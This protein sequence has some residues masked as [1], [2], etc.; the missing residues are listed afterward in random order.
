MAWYDE[1]EWPEELRI[2][3]PGEDEDEAISELGEIT[4]LEQLWEFDDYDY[5]LVEYEFHGTGDTGGA[6]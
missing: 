2:R 6:Q 5:D 3:E 4:D 1:D